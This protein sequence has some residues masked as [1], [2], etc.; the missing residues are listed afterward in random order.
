ML[1]TRFSYVRACDSFPSKVVKKA[2]VKK[3]PTPKKTAAA[4]KKTVTK[5]KLTPKKEVVSPRNVELLLRVSP[6]H[7]RRGERASDDF[8]P[9]KCIV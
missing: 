2:G 5:K 6:V 4:K 9:A 7:L 3:A 8:V 1:E